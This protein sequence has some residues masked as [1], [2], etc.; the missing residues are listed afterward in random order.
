MLR[1]Q[2]PRTYEE[3]QKIE[4]WHKEAIKQVKYTPYSQ[5]DLDGMTLVRSEKEIAKCKEIHSQMKNKTTEEKEKKKE[6]R[7]EKR[8]M[9]KEERKKNIRKDNAN[10][11]AALKKKS[12]KAPFKS[13][14]KPGKKEYTDR[15]DTKP[16]RNHS[17]KEKSVDKKKEISRKKF[18]TKEE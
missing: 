6:E 18:N 2:K 15:K 17:G 1:D 9:Q 7:R 5:K 3:Q 16:S 13:S 4:E 10:K 11:K 14:G 8:E 12:G